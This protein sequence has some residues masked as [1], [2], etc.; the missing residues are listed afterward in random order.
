[1]ARLQYQPATR[2]RGFQPIQLSRAGIARMDEEGNRVIRN[3]EQQRDAENNQRRDNLQAMK[4]NSAYEQQEQERN[5][6]ILE[7]NRKVE[8]A[9]NA[10]KA[11]SIEATFGRLVNFSETLGKQAGERTKKMIVDQ[12][13]VGAKQAEESYYNNPQEQVNY[14]TAESQ[15]PV[16][17]AKYDYAILK[18][19][20]EGSLSSLEAAKSIAAN[21]A[22]GFYAQQGYD[23]Q[24]LTLMTSD[25]LARELKDTTPKY[26]DERTGK[27]FSGFEANTN[28]DYMRQ[29]LGQVST[30]L[31]GSNGLNL[32]SRPPGYLDSSSDTISKLNEAYL[33]SAERGETKLIYDNSKQEGNNLRSLGV[34]YFQEAFRLDSMN[35]QVGRTGAWKNV[36]AAFSAQAA[37]GDFL[38]DLDDLNALV[39][40]DSGKTILEERFNSQGYQ[41][42]LAARNKARTDFLSD[43]QARV[44][45]EAKEFSR[46]AYA[47]MKDILDTGDKQ[48]DADA[49]NTFNKDFL[50]RFN[51]QPVPE[52]MISLQKSALA[53]NKQAEQLAFDRQKQLKSLTPEFIAGIL[54]PEIRGKA[55]IAYK[56]QKVEMLGPDY[57]RTEKIAKAKALFVTQFNKNV[58]GK[59][60][61]QTFIFEK[62]YLKKYEEFYK[63]AIASNVSPEVAQVESLRKVDELVNNGITDSKSDFYRTTGPLNSFIFPKLEAKYSDLSALAKESQQELLKGILK[64]GIK[65]VDVP[66]ALGTVEELEESNNDFYSDNGKFRYNPEE[67]LVSKQFGIPLYAVRNARTQA[68]NKADGGNRRLIEPTILE[69]EVFDQDPRTLKLI[70]DTAKITPKRVRRAIHSTNSMDNG[71]VRASMMQTGQNSDIII[72]SANDASGEPG[73]DF[74]IS[75]GER[76]AKFYFPYSARVVAVESNSNGETN[77]ESNPGGQRGYGNYVDLE[78]TLPNGRTSDVRLAHFDDVANLQVGQILPENS[79]IGTQGRTGSTTGAHVS[80]DWYRPGTSQPDTA[81]RDWFL[82]NYLRN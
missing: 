33:N 77:L 65:I 16:A 23:N 14:K 28:R 40:T 70:T 3:L 50:N 22:R 11:K 58:V 5:R 72:T 79:F 36:W 53:G 80:A 18:D 60:N 47:R 42:A 64:K 59:E 54:N 78:V 46:Q 8:E 24:M 76:G 25:T 1:M 44:R 81:S 6:R 62:A 48:Q 57:A 7:T 39:L 41:N 34:K 55:A 66:G 69:K 82:N 9:S 52:S 15:L 31:R 75:N 29:V 2:A 30:N 67:Q 56:E 38:Y 20:A 73:S 35:P 37:N 43:D 49:I 61:Y 12:T 26:V 4:A 74:V 51:G 27:K 21:P 19:S 13:A 71:T 32:N 17:S 45:I 68:F 10:N 63:A